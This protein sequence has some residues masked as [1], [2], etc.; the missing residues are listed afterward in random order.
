MCGPKVALSGLQAYADYYDIMDLSEEL[1]G[2]CADAVVGKRQVEYQGQVLDL[3]APFRR[4]SM[5]EL[6]QQALGASLCCG[7]FLG[8]VGS[9]MIRLA[10]KQRFIPDCL[11]ALFW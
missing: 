6:V 3:G 7:G 2:A 9:R 1:I 5:H 4:A 10:Q 8:G 11:V